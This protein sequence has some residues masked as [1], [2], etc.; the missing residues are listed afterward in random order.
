MRIERGVVTFNT[1]HQFY[2]REKDGSKPYTI[3]LL[4]FEEYNDLAEA[5]P[6]KIRIEH[7]AIPK[8]EHFTRTILSRLILSSMLGHHLV[9]IAWIHEENKEMPD[10]AQ[11]LEG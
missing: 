5:N 1:D 4:T 8:S 2:Y 3:R 6:S 7:L 11:D 9:G 10:E